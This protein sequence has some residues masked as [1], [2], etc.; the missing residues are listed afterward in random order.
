MDEGGEKSERI[1]LDELEIPVAERAEAL[2]ALDEALDRLGEF[3]TRL[4]QVV[5]CRF[6]AG[7]TEAETAAAV[8]V[9]QRTVA[10][11]WAVARGW[12]YQELR[13]DSG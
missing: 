1:S 2:L 10:R 9:S 8:G 12:L 3:D 6:F 5:E 11:E 4:A 7:L 13:R